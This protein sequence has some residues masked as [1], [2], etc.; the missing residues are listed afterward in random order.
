M[1]CQHRPE[2]P[3]KRRRL[4]RSSEETNGDMTLET[5]IYNLD[6]YRCSSFRSPW[7]LPFV[8]EDPEPDLRTNGEKMNSLMPHIRSILKNNDVEK[9]ISQ[10]Q[11][12]LLPK[13]GY[14]GGEKKTLTLIIYVNQVAPFTASWADARDELR[15]ML[16]AQG[17]DMQIEILGRKRAFMPWLLPLKPNDSAVRTYEAKHKYLL[18]VVKN[19]MNSDWMAMSLFKLGSRSDPIKPALVVLVRPGAVRNWSEISKKLRTIWSNVEISIEFL[20]G[21]IGNLQGMGISL[22]SRLTPNPQIGS[23]IGEYKKPAPELLAGI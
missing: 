15:T 6:G 22:R 17:L 9:Q 8:V 11:S 4:L 7:P 14:P 21:V 3:Q 2:S 10:I 13:L 18:M 16:N 23:S 12:A 20:P 1:D 5:Y 19:L